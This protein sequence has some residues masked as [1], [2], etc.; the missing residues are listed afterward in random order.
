MEKYLKKIFDIL[1]GLWTLFTSFITPYLLF[2]SVLGI[3]GQIRRYDWSVHEGDEEVWIFVGTVLLVCWILF[4]W[5]PGISFLNRL[6]QFGRKKYIG[7]L[8]FLI[9]VMLI[10]VSV[11]FR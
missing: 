10:G 1:W 7:A 3:T 5:I 9:I 11:I 6:K 8:I 4:A 2:L